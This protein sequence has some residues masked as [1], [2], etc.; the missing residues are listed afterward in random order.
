MSQQQHFVVFYDL[1]A[2]SWHIEFDVSIASN[3]DGE[4]LWDSETS[5]WG[6]LDNDNLMDS[7]LDEL[8]GRLSSL[9]MKPLR[10]GDED[11]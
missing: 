1:E 11:V 9:P 10:D 2:E 4:S 8:K 6:Y 3:G 5:E 7:L